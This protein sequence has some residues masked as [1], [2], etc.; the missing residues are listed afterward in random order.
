M[1]EFVEGLGCRLRVSGMVADSI[2]MGIVNSA[3]EEAFDKA[4]A[5]E[6]DIERLNEK[7]RFCVLAVMQ[8]EW[9]LK[10]VQEETDG[11]VV[12][13]SREREKLVS[14]LTETRDRIQGRLEETEVAISDKDRELTERLENELRLR[15]ALDLREV[16]LSSLRDNLELERTKSEGVQ[17][18]ILSNRVGG[19]ESRDGD[20]CELKNSVDQQFWNIK[21]KLEDERI[22]LTKGMRKMSQGPSNTLN[23]EPDSKLVEGERNRNID[24]KKI[25]LYENDKGCA[26]KPPNCS[27]RPEVNIGFE[28]MGSDI[29]ILKETL[30][31]AFGLMDNAI[32]LSEVGPMEQQW[33]WTIEKDTTAVVL[34]GFMWDLQ[35]NFKTRVKEVKRQ[36][37]ME[38]L[39]ENWSELM[40]EITSLHH[41]LEFL[42]NQNKVQVKSGKGN[43]SSAPPP[44]IDVGCKI[45]SQKTRGKP[46]PV[47]DNVSSVDRY[48][49]FDNASTKIEEADHMEKIPGEDPSGNG[50]QFVAKMIKNHESIIRKKSEELNLLKVEIF[51]EKDGSSVRNDKEPDC[52]MKMVEDIIVRLDSVIKGNAKL[53]VTLDDHRRVHE[54]ELKGMEKFPE[55]V[56][57][58]SGCYLSD[59]DLSE[60]MRILKLE[61]EESNLQTMIMEETYVIIVKGLMKELHLELYNHDIESLIR[62]DICKIIFSNILKEW[63]ED[64]ENNNIESHIREEIN[65]IV[66]SEAVKDFG[67]HRGFAI[68]AHEDV[69]NEGNF[70]E[71]SPSTNKLFQNIEGLIR[72]DV[73]TVFLREMINGWNKTL[74]NYNVESL[75]REEIYGTV[76]IETVKDMKTTANF[77]LT[78]CQEGIKPD[79]FQEDVPSTSKKFQ[80]LESLVREDVHTV[81][82]SEMVKEWKMELEN[83]DMESLIRED[84]YR[85][86]ISEAVKDVNIFLIESEETRNRDDF[87]EDLPSANKLFKSPEVSEKENLIQKLGSLSK[88]FEVEEDLMLSV[89]S[90]IMEKSVLLDHVDLEN[91]EFD[92]CSIHCEGM[93][94]EKDDALGS[95][96][97][98]L[99]KALQQLLMSKVILRELGSS[100]GI[101]VGDLEGVHDQL[102][103]IEGIVQDRQHSIFLPENNEKEQLNSFNPMVTTLREFPEL[104]VDFE[105]MVHEKIGWNIWRLDEVKYQLDP[106]VELV[107]S[108]RKKEL[109]YREAFMRRCYDLQKAEAEVDL[110]G[111]QVEA[112]LG[113]LEKIYI[114]L[115]HY[116]PVLQHYFGIVD[117]LKL[118]KEKL[119][120]IAAD[121][122]FSYSIVEKNFSSS[123][124]DRRKLWS[125][126][127]ARLVRLCF[128]L[129]LVFLL[130]EL[131]TSVDPPEISPGPAPEI[132]DHSPNPQP[133]SPHI[134]APASEPP[135]PDISSPPAPPPADHAPGTSPT[136]SSPGS[137]PTPSPSDF[138]DINHESS[139]SG[140]DG[141]ESKGSSG[142]L[143][144]GQKAGIV[145]G[146]IIGACLIGFG[147]LVYKKRR[148]N[149]RRTEYG[150]GVRREFL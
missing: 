115:N 97:N 30:D 141:L 114:T 137:S 46:F 111:D 7:S 122:R 99:E 43:D 84:I 98:K 103:P 53:G 28:Q 29:D 63:N 127:M 105:C 83:Y 57:N 79:K 128:S 27:L 60:E 143:K 73:C 12:E 116:S 117:I 59:A 47:C 66:F 132:G 44:Q 78:Q 140:G 42:I 16:E 71:Y 150:Y 87:L 110:L 48:S 75:V 18:F 131:T 133:P 135:L 125:L 81:F 102:T 34:K 104:L 5:K 130:A 148:D 33:R 58:M 20:F 109:L 144:G 124:E 6:G 26:V 119:S 112:L 101:K 64:T 85:I 19:D 62:E 56:G 74:E 138:G 89:S 147:G 11:Y 94:V 108:L 68:T 49:K 39:I 139:D 51:R 17:E 4:C 15:Q 2:M 24:S 9:C 146:V 25:D 100:L 76:F 72:E 36:V 92:E 1:E 106:L 21:Q 107:A 82:F 10:F 118:M 3:M 23:L 52:L 32:S 22:N 45:I 86:A 14:D 129:L 69:G 90:E 31:L 96:S 113:L 134:G 37:P 8:L 61:I 93:S 70:L 121:L 123:F 41:E 54:N 77:A 55:E 142:G 67:C 149:I 80:S 126:D 38:L 88:C 65:H 120:G 136:P 91:E 95:M 40:N 50:S 145:V 13:S 35:E